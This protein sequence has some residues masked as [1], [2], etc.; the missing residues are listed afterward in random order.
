[1]RRKKK[2]DN[3]DERGKNM[4]GQTEKYIILIVKQY[5]LYKMIMNKII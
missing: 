4:I 5:T 1:M 2:N 3:E